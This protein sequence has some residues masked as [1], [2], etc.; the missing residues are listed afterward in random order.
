MLIQSIYEHMTLKSGQSAGVQIQSIYEHMT[1]K[2]GQSAEKYNMCLKFS[3]E[4]VKLAEKFQ[5]CNLFNTTIWLELLNPGLHSR[6]K[7]V[8]PCQYI[9]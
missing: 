2:S 6:I 4:Y 8:T 9:M 1:L 3:S 7:A 5:G